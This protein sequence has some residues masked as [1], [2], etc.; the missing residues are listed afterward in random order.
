MLLCPEPLSIV[1][2]DETSRHMITTISFVAASYPFGFG[3]GVK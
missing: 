2:N 3:C 1:R